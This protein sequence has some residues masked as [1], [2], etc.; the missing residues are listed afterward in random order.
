MRVIILNNNI[1]EPFDKQLQNFFSQDHETKEQIFASRKSGT[2]IE[3][4]P[5]TDLPCGEVFYVQSI[6]EG[7]E[8][9][10]DLPKLIRIDSEQIF[11]EVSHGIF[12]SAPLINEQFKS[13]AFNFLTSWNYR[14]LLFF[15][16]GE[17]ILEKKI[18]TRSRNEI[19]N[20]VHQSF[21]DIIEIWCTSWE[22][23]DRYLLR[24]WFEWR[25][26]GLWGIN[27]KA[28]EKYGYGIDIDNLPLSEQTKKRMN[29]MGK[30]HDT[31]LD[32][33]NPGGDSPWTTEDWEKY[34]RAE[35]LLLEDLRKELS[36]EYEIIQF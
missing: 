5:R 20:E 10:S 9:K 24:Y 36:D 21:D 25:G 27:R 23:F 19:V 32:W 2:L 16:N 18:D 14:K 4:V 6:E 35:A 31:A 8:L 11:I 28:S 30:W 34:E 17:L 15:K 12:Y 26:P 29:E 22:Y 3:S 7:R 13:S 33:N 1:F